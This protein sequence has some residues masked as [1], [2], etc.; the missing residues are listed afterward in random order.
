MYGSESKDTWG[1]CTFPSDCIDMATMKG[2]PTNVLFFQ[3]LY[4]VLVEEVGFILKLFA[5][6]IPKQINKYFFECKTKQVFNRGT[7]SV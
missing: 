6:L 5:L 3:L 1:R 2:M 7:S 4:T